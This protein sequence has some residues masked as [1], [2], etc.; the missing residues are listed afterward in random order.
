L[1]N[2]KGAEEEQQDTGEHRDD[3]LREFIR[4]IHFLTPISPGFICD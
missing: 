4:L 2:W 3:S 1:E